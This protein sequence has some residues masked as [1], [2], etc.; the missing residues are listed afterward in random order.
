MNQSLR[1]LALAA[2]LAAA[3]SAALVGGMAGAKASDAPAPRLLVDD[4]LPE[5]LARGLVVLNYR[6]EHLQFHPLFKPAPVDT[7]TPIGHLHV[8]VD[9][10]PWHWADASGEPLVIQGL[11]AGPHKIL[12]ELANAKHQVIDSK[13]VE[14][15][16][17]QLKAAHH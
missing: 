3:A 5:T 11:T 14:V 2:L 12:V 4:P 8:T 13:T 10:S 17:P 1:R 9:D 16:I 6:A 15:E 7:T